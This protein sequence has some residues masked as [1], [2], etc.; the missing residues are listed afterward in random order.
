[1]EFIF[2]NVNN[3]AHAVDLINSI[4]F[5]DQK[6]IVAI[7]EF[8]NIKESLERLSSTKAVWHDE[9]HGR[10]GVIYSKHI[11]LRPYGG[12]K[13]F[14]VYK[15]QHK[16]IEM[17]LAVV[18]LKSQYRSESTSARINLNVVKNILDKLNSFKN[19]Y[20]IIMGDF[21]MP[22]CN[23][24]TDFYHLNATDYFNS[25]DKP[26][27]TCEGEKRIKFYSPIQSFSGDISKGP[28]GSYY[29]PM[30]TQSQAWHI[31]DN[32]L[33]SYPLV[34]YLDREQC[35]IMSNMGETELLKNNRP[36][37]QISDHLP[38]KIKL[39]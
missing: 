22:L 10:T 12:E 28:P 17:L 15:T 30:Q 8:W 16:G 13:Y 1:M 2:W 5:T 32:V 27:K 9:I 39:A 21:N 29:Y 4:N 19:E 20:M 24:I 18:H 25:K 6:R 14:S 38:I 11:P 37:K 35:E 36:N 31:F 33:V 23:D 3:N 34:E 7:S 26:Y